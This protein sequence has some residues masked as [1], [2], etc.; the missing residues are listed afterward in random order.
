M[1]TQNGI[2]SNWW[3]DKEKIRPDEIIERVTEDALLH[4]LVD[5]DA[6]DPHTGRTYGELSPFISTTAGTVVRDALGRR[7]LELSAE[8]TA[9]FFATDGFRRPGWIFSGYVFT[10]GRKAVAQVGFAEEVRELNIYTD[11]LP[12]Q[13]E[14]EIVAKVH[15]PAVQLEEAWALE[16]VLDRRDASLARWP[17]ITQRLDNAGVYV[18][19]EELVNL[20]EL[21]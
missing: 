20:R 16:P 10:L 2:V 5:Y 17:R 9:T 15:V 21:L 11:Y 7:N 4:H 19:P 3:R 13:P 6:Y 1:L 18:P 14:G 8:Y 12:F